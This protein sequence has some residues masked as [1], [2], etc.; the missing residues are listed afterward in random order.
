MI[1]TMIIGGVSVFLF[2]LAIGSFLNVVIY[3]TIHGESPFEGRSRCPSC[4][5]TIRAIDNIPLISYLFLGGRCRYCRTKISWTYPVIELLTGVLFVWWFLTGSL[6]FKLTAAPFVYLQPLFWLTVG[7]LLL[8]LFFADFLYGILPDI[9]VVLLGVLAL[10]YRVLLSFTGIMQWPDFWLS[11]ASGI[12][13][14]LF[15]YTLHAFTRGRGM[16]MGD[17]KLGLAFGVLLG[18]PRTLVA[19]F[20]SFIIGA[21]AGVFLLASGRRQFGQT[22]PFGPFLVLGTV[23]SLLWGGALWT[24]YMGMLS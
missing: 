4:K 18:W 17:V 20:A 23:V 14:S 22:I 1:G 13:A 11:I 2:G 19:V 5:K 9:L 3:R 24:W 16:G 7:T 12:G 10:S 6:F 15:F 21:L 8:V